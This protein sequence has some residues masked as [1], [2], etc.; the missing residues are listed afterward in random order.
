MLRDFR[1][2]FSVELGIFSLHVTGAASIAGAVNYISTAFVGRSLV[3]SLENTS[4]YVWAMVV[5]ALMLV[6]SLPVLAG[7]LTMLLT[8]RNFN[9]GFFVSSV[10]GDPVLFQHLF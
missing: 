2:S 5:T 6:I 1:R 4:L 7:G 3:V 9:T 10:G 8:D